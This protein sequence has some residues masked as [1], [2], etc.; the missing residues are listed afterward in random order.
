MKNSLY[1]GSPFGIRITVHWTFLI[2]IAYITFIAYRQGSNT[3]Q[4]LFS[5]LF[6]LLIFVC[7][8]LH[9]L[10]HALAAKRYGIN[11]RGIT[12]L[13]IGGV[14]S[15][16][17]IPEEP[18]RE[19]FVAIAGPLVNVGIA[20][21][22]FLFL[23]LSGFDF[24]NFNIVDD[25]YGRIL[26]SL[27]VVNILLVLFNVIPAFPMDG[28]RIFRALL[29]MKLNRVKAT[30]IAARTGQAFAVLF[31]IYGLYKNNIFLIV[32][33][34]FV[35]LAAQAELKDVQIKSLL[36]GKQVRDLLIRTFTPVHP[37][38]PL[39]N[40]VEHL[41][42]G[43]EEE[44]I[45]IDDDKPVGI[46]TKNNIIKGISQHGQDIFTESVMEKDFFT[47]KIDDLVKD[48][49]EKMQSTDFRTVPVEQN[50]FIIGVLDVKN[51]NEF[52]MINQAIER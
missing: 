49:F 17:K 27:M 18:R 10:G 2:L 33:A 14:A 25:D 48:V 26:P 4:I 30:N 7:V 12:L 31:T 13:P 5:I 15:L 51:I 35:F 46:L 42:N 11:T 6:I 44:F 3:V 43:H 29:A 45:V 1:I 50:G 21:L 24:Y 39:R 9:E 40:V 8:V 28:G 16:D 52:M 38:L 22:L 36:K 37:K 41:L 20:A 23:L 34:G 47:A 32:I 19:L